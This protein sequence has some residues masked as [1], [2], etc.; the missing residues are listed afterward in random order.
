MLKMSLLAASA[1]AMVALPATADTPSHIMAADIRPITETITDR[2]IIRRV[3][4]RAITATAIMA[5]ATMVRAI[6]AATAAAMA[7]P[8]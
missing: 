7:P 3:T 2:A 4:A 8:A 6:I 1:A 5:I